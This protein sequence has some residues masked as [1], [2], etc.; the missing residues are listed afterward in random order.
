V[1]LFEEA[2]AEPWR[3]DFF[4]TM[5]LLERTYSQQPRISDSSSLREEYVT[6]GQDPYL[7]FPASN[8]TAV[9]KMPAGRLRILTRFLGLLGPQ[10]ALPLATTEEA[11]HW[12]LMR[13]DAFPRFLDLLNNRFLQLFFRAWS[14][15]QPI[16]QH[17]RPRE[18]RFVAYIGSTVGLG[19]AI[20]QNLDSVPDAAKLGFAG[21]IGAQARGA[22]RLR[23]LI[24][25]LFDVKVEI[26]EFVGS[27]LEFDP[28]QRTRMGQANSG[29][30]STLLLG[31]AVFSI[32][33]KFRIRI[34][35]ADMAEYMKFLPSGPF[36]EPL[37][38]LVFFY[39]GDQLSWEVELAIPS[40]KVEP[41]RLSKFGQLGWTT[42][43]S[44]KWAGDTEEYRRDARFHPADIL[45]EK[46][47]RAARGRQGGVSWP[48]ST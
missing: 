43:M 15:A 46:R 2:S 10:G 18:D 22:S 6:L 3:F 14:D 42:W 19:S 33:D 45:K 28:S 37:A 7:E 32:E 27:Y 40:G 41:V 5:R 48:K 44:P 17:D 29:L 34:Y 20:F 1:N 21:L 12:N 39:I 38:D 30:G 31:S 23:S 25:G 35:V 16:A 4:W 8:L 13:D 26:D 24:S 47:S 36:S 11:Y 9:E